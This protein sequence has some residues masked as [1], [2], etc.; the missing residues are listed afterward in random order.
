[1]AKVRSPFKWGSLWGTVKKTAEPQQKKLKEKVLDKFVTALATAIF[2]LIGLVLG[3][4][5]INAWYNRQVERQLNPPREVYFEGWVNEK[6][7]LAP[8]EGVIVK[9]KTMD[10]EQA[11]TDKDGYF[12]FEME[13]PPGDHLYE[14]ILVKEGFDAEPFPDIPAPQTKGDTTQHF[15]QIEKSEFSQ[16]EF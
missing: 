11:T 7:T 9:I 8:L 10:K 5:K 14:F 16:T 12:I 15:F 13:V 4:P 2:L 1:M 3:F 6:Y